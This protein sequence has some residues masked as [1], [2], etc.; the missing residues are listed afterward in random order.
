MKLREFHDKCYYDHADGVYRWESNG[1]IPLETVLVEAG[2]ST[3][4]IGR[5]NLKREGEVTEELAAVLVALS[6]GLAR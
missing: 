1:T 2:V 6:R 3:E 5:C 4:I